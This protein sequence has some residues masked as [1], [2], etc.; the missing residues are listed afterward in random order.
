MS[1]LFEKSLGEIAGL[2]QSGEVKA[3]DAVTSCIERI[4][5][6]E[7]RVQALLTVMKDE[8]LQQAEAMDA[9]GPDAEKA[10]WGVPIVLKDLLAAKGTKTTCA[11]KILENFVPFYD[12]TAVT[13][14]REA[15]A[16]IIGKANMDEFAMGSSTENSAYMKTLNPWD[17]DR[18]PGGSSGGSG[19]T[20]AAGQCYAALGTDT[21]GS[22]RLPASFC[23]IVGL[24]PTYGRIS[25]FGLIAYGSSLDQIG[26]MTRNVEDSARLLQVMAGHDPKDSTSVDVP[27]PDYLAALGRESLE[28]VTIGLPEEYW[29]EG[30]DE[31][32]EQACRDAVKKMEE[33]GAKT[34]PVKLALTDYAIATYY[35]IAMAEASSNLSRF[36]GVR[37]GHRNMEAEELIDMYTSSRTEGFGDEVQRRII[38]G[39]YVLSSGYYDAYYNKAAKVRRLLREDFEKAFEQ[40][41]IIAGPV[42]PTTAFK[43]GEKADP[44]QMYL[45][46]IFT[47]SCNLAGLPGMSL[48]V[49]LGKDSEMPVGLQFMGPAFSEDVMLSVA[50]CLE[51]N[52]DPMPMPKL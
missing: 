16:I 24:K 46:D 35:I 10:L 49:G 14:L 8:A 30:L 9:E 32:V 5:A 7:P 28:G 51:R 50:E 42:C 18:V 41:D 39:T 13:K 22:I 43:A 26:P 2:L 40:C 33:L 17:L 3:V 37:F 47:I 31:E 48:P 21:G 4:E 12:A 6:T 34:V 23:G 29:G 52:I 44:L 25:R 20:V 27:V 11:S 36:D 45:M 38:I 1:E 15:G 19:A